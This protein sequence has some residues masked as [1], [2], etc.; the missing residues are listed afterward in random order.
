MYTDEEQEIV[1]TLAADL[2]TCVEENLTAFVTGY[3]SLD[4]WDEFVQE[5]HAIGL[6]D[7]LAIAQTA[8]DRLYK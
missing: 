5:V 2:K 1:S 3:R 7:Y 4:E 8:Y 6:E